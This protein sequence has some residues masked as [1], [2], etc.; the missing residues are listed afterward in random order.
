MTVPGSNC[1]VVIASMPAETRVGV[2]SIKN[3]LEFWLPTKPIIAHS[4]SY[5][6]LLDDECLIDLNDC[7]GS[8][9]FFEAPLSRQDSTMISWKN[10]AIVWLTS[11][12]PALT[13]TSPKLL[14]SI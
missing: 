1:S 4:R 10:L 7:V 12:C 14:T 9:D 5:Y 8:V 2:I 3:P 6:T 11:Q 13:S